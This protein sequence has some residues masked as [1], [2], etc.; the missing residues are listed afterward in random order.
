MSIKRTHDGG[1][2]GCGWYRSLRRPAQRNLR[3]DSGRSG[4][5]RRTILAGTVRSSVRS[6]AVCKTEA[7]QKTR[8]PKGL[9]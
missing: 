7:S 2:D 1:V 4:L 3:L 6:L 8:A 9:G 5:R